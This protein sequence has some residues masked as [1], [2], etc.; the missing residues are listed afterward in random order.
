MTPAAQTCAIFG[1]NTD[2]VLHTGDEVAD[3]NLIA[4]FV[5]HYEREFIASSSSRTRLPLF[6]SGPIIGPCPSRW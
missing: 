1:S 3:K 6:I 2:K 4:K 5:S